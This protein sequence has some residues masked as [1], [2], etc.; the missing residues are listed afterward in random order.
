MKSV[1]NVISRVPK[2]ICALFFVLIIFFLSGAVSSFAAADYSASIPC[3]PGIPTLTPDEDIIRT[4]G[5]NDTKEF[6]IKPASS[7][8]SVT[9]KEWR[10]NGTS[11]TDTSMDSWG[12]IE[13]SNS[14]KTMRWTLGKDAEDKFKL[15]VKIRRGCG[16]GGEG[17]DEVLDLWDGEVVTIDSLTWESVNSTLDSNSKEGEGKR[18]FPDMVSPSDSIQRNIVEVKAKISKAKEGVTIYF[19][20]FDVDDPSAEGSA[21]DYDANGHDGN[22]NRGTPRAGTLNTSSATTDA[23]GNATVPFKVT[24]QPGDNFRIAASLN[25]ASLDQLTVDEVL[26][27]ENKNYVTA[28][29]TQISDFDG[30]ITEM[31][32]VWRKLHVEVDTMENINGNT[33]TTAAGM[34]G[35]TDVDVL[36]NGNIRCITDQTLVDASV[37]P[38]RFENGVLTDSKGHSFQV[39]SNTNGTD[40]EIIVSPTTNGNPAKGIFTMVDDDPSHGGGDGQSVPSPNTSLLAEKFEPA[41]IDVKLD[42]ASF[43]WGTNAPFHLNFNTTLTSYLKTIGTESRQ[44]VSLGYFWATHCVGV[45]QPPTDRLTDNIYGGDADPNP[46]Y[47]TSG[48]Q[49]GGE[50]NILGVSDFVNAYVFSEALREFRLDSSSMQAHV[51][52]H[53]VGHTFDLQDEYNY[54]APPGYNG[55]MKLVTQGVFTPENL[56][57]IRSINHPSH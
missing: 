8:V 26:N 49:I 53:E 15:S 29:S 12:D 30:K 45:F 56:A 24:M 40:F 23:D 43:G 38:G 47:D 31:L 17:E 20:A 9:V 48:Q 19:K 13:L 28:G 37:Q 36:P 33:F 51:L 16:N 57:T 7:E 22:D 54:N 2:V 18:I 42:G 10:I 44:S 52:V 35:I 27:G 5:Q 6:E 46:Q 41:Y 50:G 11:V 4:K 14:N 55:I 21:L 34:L 3:P 1:L 39:I 32:T 25:Q